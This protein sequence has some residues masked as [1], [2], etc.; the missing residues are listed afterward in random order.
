MQ[1]EYKS[2]F[3]V[4][5]FF[6]ARLKLRF[7][8][9]A[10]SLQRLQKEEICRKKQ[11]RVLRRKR[12]LHSSHKCSVAAS[13]LRWLISSDHRRSL[14]RSWAR[15][16]KS[17]TVHHTLGGKVPVPSTTK[18]DNPV[19][20][21]QVDFLLKNCEPRLAER[22]VSHEVHDPRL[23]AMIGNADQKCIDPVDTIQMQG[24]TWFSN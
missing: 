18:A 7:N 20:T 11:E 23:R 9:R 17:S 4:Q 3:H 1:S 15:F 8:T 24:V 5:P 13:S 14:E 16:N 10:P 6:L 22:P 12:L 21:Q 19:T 2:I